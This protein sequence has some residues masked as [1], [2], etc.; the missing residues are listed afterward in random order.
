MWVCEASYSRAN[1]QRSFLVPAPDYFYEE[2]S[3]VS[4]AKWRRAGREQGSLPSM[5]HS[6]ILGLFF[7]MTTATTIV[8]WSCMIET[9][10][11]AKF[12]NNLL[13]MLVI[14]L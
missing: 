3:F 9:S 10:P 1:G 7:L 5:K 13:Q 8:Y 4:C 6:V 12:C 2:L 14:F 11:P